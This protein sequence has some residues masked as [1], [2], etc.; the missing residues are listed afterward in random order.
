MQAIVYYISLPFIYLISILPF[1][2]LYRV[3]DLL[4]FFIYIL[5][6]YRKNIVV[7]NLKNSFPEKT[8]K[9][10]ARMTRQFYVFFCDW[11][12]ETIKSI[13]IS[14]ATAIKRCHFTNTE[15]LDKYYKANK[16]LIFVMGH[17]GSFELGGAAI[18]THTNYQLHTIFK[19]L[20]N[21]YFDRL[22]KHKRI[23]FNNK[24]IA[25]NDTFRTMIKLKDTKELNAT[26]FIADQTPQKNNAYWTTFLNQET[27]IF[28]GT[29]I[30]AKKL[31][32]PIIYL[33]IKQPKRGYYEITPEL[34]CDNPSQTKT[35]EISEMHTNRLEQD[36]KE[37]PEIWLWSHRRWKHKKP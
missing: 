4:Y 9:E 29:E 14:R 37:Q 31:N 15:I 32:Y 8:D 3:S 30:I 17:M 1:W 24:V 22:I 7:Q 34:L 5:L 2:L 12:I 10:I 28:W 18:S 25:M 26:L 6:G 33:S 27:P 21:K 36:I 20:S 35:G 23:R 13:T 11:T 16:K 19:P